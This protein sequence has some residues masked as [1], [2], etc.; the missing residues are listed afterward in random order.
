MPHNRIIVRLKGGLG[1]Q[2]FQYAAAVA[3]AQR[4]GYPLVADQHSGFARDRI[5]QR[6]YAL[7]Y[8]P[9]CQ[10]SEK[11]INQLPFYLEDLIDRYAMRNQKSIIRKRPWGTFLKEKVSTFYPE[12]LQKELIG[13]IWLDGYWQSER[14]F[15]DQMDY[16]AELYRVPPPAGE[17]YLRLRD[18]LMN[19]NA[20][21]VGIRLYE[22]AP[23]K[24]YNYSPFDFIQHAAQVLAGHIENPVF[25]LFCTIRKAIEG[26]L[27]LP[28]KVVYVTYDDGFNDEIAS[29]WLLSQFQTHIISHSSFYW[30]GA[31]ISEQ[32][33]SN[34]RIHAHNLF[35]HSIPSRWV[36]YE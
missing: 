16:I 5:Y 32:N 22:E 7:N 11:L 1:N 36:R 8:F 29:L 10:R 26:V 35:D 33:I 14:Y 25:Y 30:W 24:I 4:Y 27:T 34:V 17:S 2:M 13:N 31:W 15:E 21:A 20:I 28:G 6:K 19:E 12:L 9:A 18:Q 3:L 23:K